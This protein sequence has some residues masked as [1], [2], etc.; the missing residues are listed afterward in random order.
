MKFRAN[1]LLSKSFLPKLDP[2]DEDITQ[3]NTA[4]VTIREKIRGAFK[5]TRR[6]ISQDDAARF[7]ITENASLSQALV[8][9]IRKLDSDQKKALR[10]TTPKFSPQGSFVYK[11]ANSPCHNPPQQIDFDDGVYLPTDL[12]EDRPIVS[13][14]LFFKIV[15]DALTE[16]CAEQKGWRFDNSKPTCA[17]IILDQRKHIDIPLYAI[18]RDRYEQM[19]AE[20]A[21]N[22]SQLG[23]AVATRKLLNSKDVFMAMRNQAHWIKSD[24]KLVSKWF[25][26]SIED[27]GDILRRVCRYLKAWRD[28]KFLNGGPSSITLMACAVETFQQNSK[29]GHL[30]RDD[31]EALLA[32]ATCLF[33]QL[34]NGVESPVDES[35]PNLFP[36]DGVSQEER[37]RILEIARD[38]GAGMKSAFLDAHSAI[39]AN[40]KLLSLF[41]T[42]FPFTPEAIEITAAAAV[43]RA[44][45]KPQPQPEVKNMSGG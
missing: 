43:L 6:S 14:D 1:T 26:G 24:P 41:G 17:R 18:P 9:S 37:Q 31:S 38:L 22:K 12:F 44:K 34:E 15:D 36:R 25:L 21:L 5:E 42:R 39:E 30:F 28:N 2:T 23:D 3:L 8:E 11:T 32:C 16:L 29:R 19:V 10:N 4:R 40:T 13:K 45:P 33:S 35:E 20:A 27:F 7:V